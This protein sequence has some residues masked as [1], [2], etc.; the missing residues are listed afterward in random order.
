MDSI[1]ISVLCDGARTAHADTIQRHVYESLAPYGGA[2]SA[3]HG[4]GI[5]KMPWLSISRSEAE[6]G[7]MKTLK[8]SLDPHNIL[9]PGKVISVD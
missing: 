9:N 6:I 3:E 5:E 2:I 1:E 8:R 7:L 4:I